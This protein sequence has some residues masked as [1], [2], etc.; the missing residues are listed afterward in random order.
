MFG[1]ERAAN[2]SICIII[3]LHSKMYNKS[4]HFVFD[5][6]NLWIQSQKNCAGLAAKYEKGQSMGFKV[7]Q[8]FA[9]TVFCF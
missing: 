6:N 3:K 9:P 4:K 7:R 1:N 8:N 2:R 5:T